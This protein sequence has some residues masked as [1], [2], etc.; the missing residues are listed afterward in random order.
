MGYPILRKLYA[1]VVMLAYHLTP[2]KA[3]A[4]VEHKAAFRFIENVCSEIPR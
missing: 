1:L 4:E 2:E 3:S